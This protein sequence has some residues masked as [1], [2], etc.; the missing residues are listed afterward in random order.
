MQRHPQNRVDGVLIE[1]ARYATAKVITR[2]WAYEMARYCLLDSLACGLQGQAHPDCGRLLG[3]I[4][5]GATL[6]GGARVP[7]TK[8]L[9]EPV[10]AAFDISTAVRWLE[11]SDTW[12][13]TDG[14]H[15]S[16][17]LG[18][19]L[20]VA[21]YISRAQAAGGRRALTVRDVLA[22]LVKAYEIHGVLLIRNNFIDKGLDGIGVVAV[23]AAAVAAQML[24]GSRD[25]VLNAV[26][27]A[28]LDG[29]SPRLYRI[30]HNAGPR[31]A[32]AAGDAAARGVMHALFAVRGEPGY[33]A[34][35]TTPK[36]GVSDA[37]LHGE[38][39]VLGR[40]LGTH[41]V[42]NVL[43]K[44]PF[45]AQFHT[46]TASECALLLHP[47]VKG[48]IDEI[49]RVHMRTHAKT[50][51]SAYKIGPLHNAASRDHCV[52]YVAA[53]VLLRGDLCSEDY[54][55]AAAID[56]R[57]DALRD[58]MVVT[59]EKQF[60]REFYDASI[61]S[62]TNAMQVEFKDG[63]RTPEMVIRYP[64]GHPRRR[65][66]ALPLVES[67]FRRSVESF[68]PRGRH[69]IVLKT[70]GSLTRMQRLTFHRFIELFS[71]A[72]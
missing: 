27:N 64:I 31:K 15:P 3:P 21:D 11:Y 20:G 39:V 25:Q 16:D 8:H 35:L 65:K 67:K 54:E 45:P 52:Q 33:P 44:V 71:L 18:A 70:C 66:E 1:I 58:K 26:S 62:N 17:T 36:W 12:F 5:P 49:A 46:Q 4:V 13:G 59:E 51:Q 43:F 63:S 24:G 57:I 68:L 34:A 72:A 19:V 41:I 23:A 42:E 38:P 10:K 7:G 9:L 55:D 60:T 48:R 69:A 56:P 53:V 30:G 47:L 29:A 50:M 61:R 32:W 37:V 6:A 40:P 2:R 22:A 14:G 28:W